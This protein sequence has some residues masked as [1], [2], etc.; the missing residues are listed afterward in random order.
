[1]VLFYKW[2]GKSI[3]FDWQNTENPFTLNVSN[4]CV[5]ETTYNKIKERVELWSVKQK[6]GSLA[7]SM[8]L[9][10]IGPSIAYLEAEDN[11]VYLMR[12]F[13]QLRKR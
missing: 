4:I 1:M 7:T 9:L 5:S 6:Y 2:L 12:G 11:F 8:H 3:Y 10:D 13:K